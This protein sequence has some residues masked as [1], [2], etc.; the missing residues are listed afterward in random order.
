MALVSKTHIFIGYSKNCHILIVKI[1]L[2]ILLSNTSNTHLNK[3]QNK[4]SWIIL[5]DA[6]HCVCGCGVEET[7]EH[8]FWHCY[9][10]GIIWSLIRK[11]ITVSSVDPFCLSDQFLQFGQLGGFSRGL[12]SFL[13][14]I[15]F[16]LVWVIWKEMM[17][18]RIFND[19]ED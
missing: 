10:F 6:N 11:W 3:N 12:L 5:P 7:I 16:S 9:H 1:Q 4:I 19:K 14:L 18:N 8:M 2:L 15:R 17:N 13:H